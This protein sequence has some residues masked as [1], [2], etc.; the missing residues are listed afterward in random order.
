MGAQLGDDVV[1]A[2]AGDLVF[3]KPRAQGYSSQCE[4]ARQ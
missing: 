1:H 4:P 3:P 2:E